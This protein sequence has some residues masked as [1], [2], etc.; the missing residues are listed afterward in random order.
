MRLPA[1]VAIT[2]ALFGCTEGDVPVMDA[3]TNRDA[4]SDIN[5]SDTI[6]PNN[7]MPTLDG[8]CPAV[9]C[10]MGQ[11][12]NEGQCVRDYGACPMDM[13]CPGDQRCVNGRCIPWNM[14]GFD[15]A[16]MRD[17]RPGVFSPAVQCKFDEA[18]MG[19]PFPT[20]VHVYPTVAVADLKIYGMPDG[21]PRPSIVASFS[22]GVW[23]A[24]ANSAGGIIRILD[25]RTCQVQATIGMPHVLTSG[26]PAI[27]DLDSDG[28][29]EIIALKDTTG[30]V[31]FRYNR[32]TSTWGVFW[33]STDPMGMGALNGAWTGPTIVDVDDDGMPEVLRGAYV[34]DGQ[35]G[36]FRGGATLGAQTTAYGS[37]FPAAFGVFPVVLDLDG[38]GSVEFIHGAGRWTWNRMMNDWVAAPW[39]NRMMC[40]SNC[41]EGHVAV[42]D[43][44]PY[45]SAHMPGAN[46]PEIAVISPGS[47]RIDTMDGQT[48]FGPVAIP[49][50]RGGP[51]TIADFDGDGQR[52]VAVAGSS[53][54]TV[55]DP[56]CLPM[57]N[58]PGGECNTHRP[59]RDGILWSI[60]SQDSSSGITGS[61]S[62]DFEAD[63]RVELVYA[64]ECFVRVYDG[65]TG[66]VL[67]S[68]RHSSCTWYENPVVA[69]VD[70]DYRAEI[71]LSS[72][73]ACGQP[74]VGIACPGIGPRGED[75]Q[76]PGVRCANNMDCVSGVCTEGFCRCT[77]DAECCRPEMV[78]CSY[79]CTAPPAG[80]PGM[81][82]TCRAS[83]PAGTRGVRVFSDTADRWVSSR[84]LWNQ[85]SY[86][87]T[88][89]TD[90]LR[91]PRTSMVSANWAN[92]R[93]NNFRT[94]VQGGPS[95]MGAPDI[96]VQ[97]RLGPCNAANGVMLSATV[98]NRG[99]ATIPDGVQVNFATMPMGGMPMNICT[100][101]T[102]NAIL[103]GACINVDCMWAMAPM[104]PVDIRVS[105]DDDRL[106]LECREDNNSSVI[107]RVQ[108]PSPG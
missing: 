67:A 32:G 62:F 22:N 56:D 84:M 107:P 38:D 75:S 73:F 26:P 13:H 97:T 5:N 2:L 70:G 29:P 79:V 16:C 69:D 51:P 71:V 88:N 49:G 30:I 57:A 17:V 44:G 86:N 52:E 68:Q 82:N 47:A 48:V 108:C 28:T 103:G 100:S 101:R 21:P 59:M 53:S 104:S 61:T 31:A 27:A 92:P 65:S 96:T 34:Y 9:A 80:T 24:V 58:R 106:V 43:L 46:A 36:R 55:F 74:N 72:N 12:C 60:T 18:P 98:C 105:V 40:A 83:R 63:G 37:G 41:P 7:D 94:N 50:G 8:G 91:V 81:G 15:M 1:L 11:V 33:E 64:D 25:G 14:N 85:Y 42:A 99:T 66:G 45:N 54:F 6:L 95:S 19:D 102:M 35:T 89:I 20:Y 76:H 3:R 90:E 39:F 77:M 93:L 23:T 10:P 4:T 78:E 87:V